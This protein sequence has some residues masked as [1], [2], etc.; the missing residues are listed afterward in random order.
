MYIYLFNVGMGNWRVLVILQSRPVFSFRLKK[1]RSLK[2]NTNTAQGPFF[3]WLFFSDDDNV[4][5]R[6]HTYF[7]SGGRSKTLGVNRT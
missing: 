7:N 3:C 1:S 6:V 2:E 4:I 5:Y